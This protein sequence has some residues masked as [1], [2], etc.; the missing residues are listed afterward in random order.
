MNKPWRQT[1]RFT[2]TRCNASY[3]HDEAYRHETFEC[4]ARA[5]KEISHVPHCPLARASA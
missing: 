3:L 4:P 5:Q 1:K 2:C